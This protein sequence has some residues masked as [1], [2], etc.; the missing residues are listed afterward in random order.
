MSTAPEPSPPITATR[1]GDVT[2]VPARFRGADIA[3]QIA[4]IARS[5]LAV[6]GEALIPMNPG[7]SNDDVVAALWNARVVLVAHGTQADPVFFFG[8][9]AGLAAF[10]ADL[11]S[12][13]AT[14]SRLS[15]EA[16]DRAER[17]A[18]LERVTRDGYIGDYAGM[19]IS[20]KGR[21]F[22]IARAVVWNLLDDAGVRH[23]QAARFALP[24]HARMEG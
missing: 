13:T 23:G 6:V 17:A 18:L 8:N 14:P 11:D 3:A 1:A 19:R 5:H 12:F 22:P 9:R 20:L 2:A 7:D 4:L 16:P 10:E 15:A 24:A 21:R